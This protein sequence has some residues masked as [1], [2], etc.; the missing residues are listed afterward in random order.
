MNANFERIAKDLVTQLSTRFPS[1][2]KETID[3]KPIDGRNF[4]DQDTRK[5]SFDYTDDRSGE[6]LTNVSI[7]LSDADEKPAMSV[8]W[9]KNPRDESW[10]NFLDELSDFAQTHGLDFDL[11]NPAQSNL[12]KRDPIGEGRMT[13]SRLSGTSKTSY[14]DIGEAKIIVRHSSP[15]N[16]NAPNGRTQHIDSIFIEN[17]AGERFKY[18]YKHLN[19]ARA[20]AEHIKNGGTPYDAIGTHITGLSEELAGL[21]KFK[22]Y[23]GRNE[24]LGEAMGDIT[25]KVMERIEEVK[26]E[27][28]SLQRPSYYSAFAENFE[29]RTAQIIPEEI[30]NDW[31][32][33]LT[34]RTFNEEMK[35]V[36]P[37]I[38]N[39]VGESNLPVRELS[40]DELLAERVS[41]EWL[42][43][44]RKAKELLNK[45]MTVDEVAKQLGVQGP[46]NG[47]IGSMG[48]LW[49]AINK[50]AQEVQQ[51]KPTFETLEDQFESA[52]E[53]I[54][55]EDDDLYKE[56]EVGEQ[57]MQTLKD[58][59]KQELPIGT[60]GNNVTSSLRGT[61][62]NNKLDRAFE[63]L[64]DL[65]LD[66]LDA[67]PIISAFLKSYDS[68]N[69]TNLATTLGFDTEEAPAEP[70]AEA[71]PAEA[72]P[73]PDAAAVPPEAAAVP[74]EAAP[75]A[76]PEAAPA[77]PA[78]PVAE[79]SEDY[80]D[81]KPRAKSNVAEKLFGD[82]KERVSGFFNSNEGTM[83]I[84]EEGFVTKMCK[85]LKEKYNIEPDTAKADKFDGMVERACH[86]V[87]EK[88]KAHNEVQQQHNRMMELAGLQTNEGVWD[89]IKGAVSG[90]VSG[91]KQGWSAGQTPKVPTTPEEIK[92]FQQANGLKPDGIAGRLTQAAMK[93]KGLVPAAQTA[94]PV[95]TAKTP[96]A[97]AATSSGTTRTSTNTSVQG[98]MKMGKPDGPI[99]FNGT[100]VN[101]GDPQYA[102][103]AQALIDAQARSQASRAQMRLRPNPALATAPVYQGASQERDRDFEESMSRIAKL[104]GLR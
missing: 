43:V 50:A 101:P 12:D 72:P 79:T 56:D 16:Y 85:E 33:R 102:A 81:N 62:D 3:S 54:V 39:L 6:K 9:S 30:M 20:L 8:L 75:A 97:P 100:V 66:E 58:L 31:I 21:R 10:M 34:I 94:T 89:S 14:Q 28:H 48:G 1:M 13:E 5:L 53:Q 95:P 87:M 82:I 29:A 74:P 83:T 78:A 61:I 7:S 90:A 46:N 17:A 59:F 99:T 84:G 32:D 23:V 96:A 55:K 40:A 45:G 65:G 64:A 27:I 91:A 67:R 70:A 69:D 76:P 57:A 47:M 80:I 71:P 4:R 35:S 73:A 63:L 25:S 68:E 36:F 26:R 103:A 19:G 52:I 24:A 22:G 38:Y 37:F 77:A 42:E 98:S 49:G 86:S 44:N 92:A 104:A 11:Q 41:P 18:P 15:V 88:Y 93:E 2:R 51:S 60:N